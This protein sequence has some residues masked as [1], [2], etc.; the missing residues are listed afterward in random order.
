MKLTEHLDRIYQ[1][2]ID[3]ADPAKVRGH[4][5]LIRDQVE[6]A[7]H[8]AI[9]CQVSAPS[10]MKTPRRRNLAGLFFAAGSKT[11]TGRFLVL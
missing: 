5:E 2:I 8:A 4:I 1:L 6:A 7:A 3:S 11:K 10:V 9:R